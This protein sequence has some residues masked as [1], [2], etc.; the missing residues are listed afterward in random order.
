MAEE[1]R[2]RPGDDDARMMLWVGEVLRGEGGLADIPPSL[3]DVGKP[4]GSC[5]SE[6]G[7]RSS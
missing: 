5:Q 4:R 6:V 3:S 7:C 1:T 2:T